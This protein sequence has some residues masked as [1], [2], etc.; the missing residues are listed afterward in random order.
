MTER[1]FIAA[2][3]TP[4]VYV[5]D[6]S[7]LSLAELNN[8]IG[9]VI[10][11]YET[12][13]SDELIKFII[14]VLK[15]RVHHIDGSTIA[16][17]VKYANE[18]A[19]LILPKVERFLHNKSQT[20]TLTNEERKRIHNLVSKLNITP[21]SN[22]NLNLNNEQR[23]KLLLELDKKYIAIYKVDVDNQYT[24]NV[25]YRKGPFEEKGLI[26]LIDK[27]EEALSCIEKYKHADLYI[28]DDQYT[29][30]Q[31]LTNF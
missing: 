4:N 2:M 15:N 22:G 23:A 30:L 31:E 28:A 7:S 9:Y 24:Y 27:G 19:S 5:V 3:K 21:D 25:S 29:I 18:N 6:K 11:S 13:I 8:T 12:T 20:K 10:A 1:V 14:K 17:K 26:K 16:Y